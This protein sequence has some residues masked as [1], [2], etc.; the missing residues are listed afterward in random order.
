MEDNRFTPAVPWVG[1]TCFMP[2]ADGNE[3]Q[4]FLATEFDDSILPTAEIWSIGAVLYHMVGH[5]LRGRN[6]SEVIPRGDEYGFYHGAIP[7]KYSNELGMTVYDMLQVT[8]EQRPTAQQI[9]ARI[10]AGISN[11]RDETD[12]EYII[13]QE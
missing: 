1:L 3:L 9:A 4:E 5:L 11:W 10:S 2:L 6:M 8:R 12:E 13:E 7:N